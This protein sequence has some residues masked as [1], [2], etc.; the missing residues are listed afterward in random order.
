VY[1]PCKLIQRLRSAKVLAALAFG[2]VIVFGN[3]L[4]KA[5]NAPLQLQNAPKA[6][7]PSVNIGKLPTP[8][9]TSILTTIERGFDF[10]SKAIAQTVEKVLSV[11]GSPNAYAIGNDVSGAFLVGGRFG[12]GLLHS[13]VGNPSPIRWRAIS[14]GLGL[15]ANYGRVV[16]LVYGLDKVEDMFGLYGS[17]EANLH[18]VLGA[19]TSIVTRGPVTIVIVSS[20]LGLRLSG[21]ASGILIDQD[22]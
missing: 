3:G 17:L 14:A 19:N 2:C 1:R 9:P 15:G 16:M 5:Q 13:A 8:S 21:E 10:P 22:R 4:A 12:T 6:Q 7:A 11:F 20:G 18:V